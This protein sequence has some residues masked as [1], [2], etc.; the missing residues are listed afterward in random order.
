MSILKRI[1]RAAK[2]TVNVHG[3]GR[4]RARGEPVVCPVCEGREFVKVVD[5]EVRRPMFMRWNLPWLK[6]DR[7]ATTLVCTHCTHMLSFGR[8]PEREEGG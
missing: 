2:A 4:Y 7:H 8:S 6:L 3:E 1:G 5:R